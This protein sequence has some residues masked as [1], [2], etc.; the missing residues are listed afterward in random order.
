MRTVSTLIAALISTAAA[1]PAI[2]W[3]GQAKEST[4]QSSDIIGTRDILSSAAS[5]SNDSS[6]ANV[7]FVVGRDEQGS[8]GLTGLTASGSLPNVASKYSEATTVHHF[9]RGIESIDALVE[10][11]K[12]SSTNVV[13]TSLSDYKISESSS[14]N[15]AAVGADGSVERKSEF[16]IVN[17]PADSSPADVDAAVSSAIEH[18][19]VGSVV[20]TSVRGIS[21]VKLERDIKAKQNYFKMTQKNNRRRLEDA[22]QQDEDDNE[23]DGIYF[24]N[25]TPNIFAGLLFGFFF[26]AI[27]FVGLSCMNLIAGQ[28]VYVTKYPIIG[29]EA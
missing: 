28:D 25:Y 1:A 14:D 22:D 26:I 4:K 21:E 19:K 29:R 7:V 3:S 2:V 18:S 17:V 15:A 8:E 10:G 6:L 5:G 12:G 9:V 23:N 11:A 24:V 20:L 27:T 13:K 16:I